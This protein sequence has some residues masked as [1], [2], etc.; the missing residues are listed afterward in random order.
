[1]WLVLSEERGND[2]GVQLKE[3]ASQEAYGGVQLAPSTTPCPFTSLHLPMCP[4]EPQAP[5]PDGLWPHGKNP[6]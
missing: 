5:P 4:C 2:S 1:M 3:G 6:E